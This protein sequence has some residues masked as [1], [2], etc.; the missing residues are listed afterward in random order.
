MN[1]GLKLCKGQPLL[2]AFRVSP[3]FSPSTYEMLRELHLLDGRE[4]PGSA[5]RRSASEETGQKW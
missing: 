5:I 4:H 2:A 1:W 3:R